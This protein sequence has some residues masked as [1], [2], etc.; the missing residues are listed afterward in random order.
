MT[1]RLVVA[2][3]VAPVVCALAFAMWMVMAA[4]AEPQRAPFLVLLMP[5]LM[6]GVFFE[7]VALVPLVYWLSRRRSLS[8]GNVIWGG[9]VLWVIAVSF[10][11]WVTSEVPFLQSL[12]GLPTLMIPGLALV[13]AFAFLISYVPAA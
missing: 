2:L 13:L 3:V 11:L 7:V 5:G 9:L 8:R 10:Q 1:G 6:M 12:I 4:E